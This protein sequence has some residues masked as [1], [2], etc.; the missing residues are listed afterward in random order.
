MV[1]AM[2][3][4]KSMSIICTRA[5]PGADD[6]GGH[7]QDG[8]HDHERIA[9]VGGEVIPGFELLVAGEHRSGRCWGGF[10]CR[11]G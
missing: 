2:K 10:F 1:E 7:E 8:E 11:P 3:R 6:H 9:D 5:L 4:G